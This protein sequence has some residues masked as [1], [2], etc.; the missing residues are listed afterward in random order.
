MLLSRSGRRQDRPMIPVHDSPSRAAARARSAFAMTVWDWVEEFHRQALESGDADRARLPLYHYHAYRYRE[1]D[2]DH[3][4]SLFEEGG[5][6]ARQLN[7]PWWALFYDDWRVTGMLF[8]QRDFRRVLDLAVQNT[9]E[10]RKP[11]YTQFPL[12]FSIQRNLVAAYIGIDPS[13]YVEPIQE[14]LAHLEAEVPVEGGDKYLV[15]GS[16]REFG[17]ELDWLDMAEE[18]SRRS[19]ELADADTD[20][21]SATH[22]ATF[23]YSGL[24]EVAWRRQD[25]RVLEEASAQGEEAAQKSDLQMELSEFIL[26]QAVVARHK[27]DEERARRLYRRATGRVSRLQMPPDRSFYDGLSGFHELGDEPA[28]ALQARQAELKEI[29]GMGRFAYETR[30][31]LR[32]CRLRAQLGEPLADDLAAARESARKLRHPEACLEELDRIEKAG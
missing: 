31:R 21:H 13:A 22:H 11:L 2:P 19:L 26:W 24:C 6:L 5:R 12:R 14:A 23:S 10:V 27:G 3:A 8:F 4:M 9:L 29:A 25:W 30:C 18:A 1:T 32:V 15:L 17:L 28:K 16:R 20:R 7:E